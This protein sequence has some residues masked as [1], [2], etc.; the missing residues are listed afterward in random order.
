M[1]NFKLI[2]LFVIIIVAYACK[3]GSPEN[4]GAKQVEVAIDGIFT[5]FKI[6]DFNYI[7]SNSEGVVFM[8]SGEESTAKTQIN[9]SIISYFSNPLALKML[10]NRGLISPNKPFAVA[11]TF[12][13]SNQIFAPSYSLNLRKSLNHKALFSDLWSN[14]NNNESFNLLGENESKFFRKYIF[15]DSNRS[16]SKEEFLKAMQE[17]AMLFQQAPYSGFVTDTN[18]INLNPIGYLENIAKYGGWRLFIIDNIP[19]FWNYF[20]VDESAILLLNFMNQHLFT[21]IVYPKNQLV[22]PFELNRED[23]MQSPLAISIL[24]KLVDNENA[25]APIMSFLESK[26][27]ISKAIVYN[28][29]QDSSYEKQFSEAYKRQKNN[30]IPYNYMLQSSLA[31]IDYVTDNYCNEKGFE[32]ERDTIVLLF[33]TGHVIKEIW[34][35]DRVYGRDLISIEL[36]EN[37]AQSPFFRSKFYYKNN[38]LNGSK[39]A[40]NAYPVVTKDIDDNH[41]LMELS[42]SLENIKLSNAREMALKIEVSDCDRSERVVESKLCNSVENSTM[43][44]SET[45]NTSLI[46]GVSAIKTSD[47][48]KIDGVMDSC[49]QTANWYPVDQLIEGNIIDSLDSSVRF[50]V[51]WDKGHLYFLFDVYDETKQFAWQ[52]T[53]DFCYI[54]NW[55]NGE[56]IWQVTGNRSEFFPFFIR[57]QQF[58]L[59]RGKYKLV[60]QSDE[61]LSFAN[62]HNESLKSIFYGAHL[63][64]ERGG[65]Q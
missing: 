13:T 50:K 22:S 40:S 46:N 59:K 36:S 58:K 19:L 45:A 7:I 52:I 32:I 26:M 39:F 12:L 33:S 16:I 64:I 18:I 23:V 63:F 27:V 2:Q 10:I 29:L 37:R 57:D 24:Q 31:S 11:D 51:L 62:W 30:T 25:D 14:F 9:D 49:W 61:N 20:E 47:S 48:I 60:Y 38:H 34:P 56:R 44:L 43:F 17:V 28:S 5:E 53:K 15:S 35:S 42:V 21:G 1:S 65:E 3:I 55:T 6:D 8:K 41:Y 4:R 54:E